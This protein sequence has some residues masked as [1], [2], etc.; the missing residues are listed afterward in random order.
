MKTH[1]AGLISVFTAIALVI[2]GC[3]GGGGDSA[4]GKVDEALL[5]KCDLLLANLA[6][7]TY[8]PTF[9]I[10]DDPGNTFNYATMSSGAYVVT[11]LGMKSRAAARKSIVSNHPYL[12]DY[13]SKA[14][15]DESSLDNSVRLIILEKAIEGTGL[16]LSLTSA[17]KQGIKG[18]YLDP[19]YKTLQ[20]ELVALGLE[21]DY[22]SD[23]PAGCA[24]LND[25]RISQADASGTGFNPYSDSAESKW[26]DFEFSIEQAFKMVGIT[27]TC[28]KT[29]EFSYDPC[30]K[31]DYISK[32]SDT[33]SSS[34]PVN[35][36]ERDWSSKDSEIMAKTVWCISNGYK[37]YNKATD[38]CK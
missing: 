15:G 35:P 32:G 33:P 7:L 10:V 37:D 36:W 5:A 8:S 29:G 31:K 30:G 9:A 12:A 3:G 1:R 6:K 26:A 27:N 21:T 13:L 19:S 11:N 16:T 17:Q 18:D 4:G 20:K 34:T 25:Y 22:N 2:S 24:S 38:G 28:E 23:I 14:T